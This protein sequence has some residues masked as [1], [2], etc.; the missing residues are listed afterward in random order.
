MAGSASCIAILAHAISGRPP[1][2]EASRIVP[3]NRMD[4]GNNKI[5]AES[6]FMLP[7]S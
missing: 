3:T 6:L 2:I 4:A 1:Q 7:P 5:K